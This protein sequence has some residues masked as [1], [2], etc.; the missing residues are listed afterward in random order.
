MHLLQQAITLPDHRSELGA[1]V[2]VRCSNLCTTLG[3]LLLRIS[4]RSPQRQ[5]LSLAGCQTAILSPE[6]GLCVLQSLQLSHHLQRR[7]GVGGSLSSR[8]KLS[9]QAAHS[10]CHVH[11]EAL[12]CQHEAAHYLAW[13]CL[14]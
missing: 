6:I 5:Q 10:G 14:R 12:A 13:A 2:S 11:E 4:E 1:A 8:V 7:S 9:K 3:G